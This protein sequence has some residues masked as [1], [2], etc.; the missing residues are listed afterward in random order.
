ML[1]MLV[2]CYLPTGSFSGINHSRR[3]SNTGGVFWPGKD[4]AETK[5]QSTAQTHFSFF[6]WVWASLSL[7]VAALGRAGYSFTCN[8]S[9]AQSI[10]ANKA[11]KFN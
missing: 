7:A 6:I 1:L 2:R 3:K 4:T 10:N 8:R 5:K 9:T 11:G